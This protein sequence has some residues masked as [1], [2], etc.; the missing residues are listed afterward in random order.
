MLSAGS[1]FQQ[2]TGVL[3]V[4]KGLVI[5]L[6]SSLFASGYPRDFITITTHKYI[7]QICYAQNPVGIMVSYPWVSGFGTCGAA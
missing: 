3:P 5:F 6:L 2:Q 7:N 1:S 4:A